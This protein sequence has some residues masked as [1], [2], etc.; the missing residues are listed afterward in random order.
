VRGRLDDDAAALLA[1]DVQNDFCPGGALA[2]PD[3]DA[4]VPVINRLAGRFAHIVLTQ[5]WHPPD[6]HSFASQHG[7]RRPFET[8]QL[9]YGPQTLWPDHCVAGTCGA[10]FHGG[11]DVSRAELVLRK[12]FRR[13]IDSYSAFFENDRRTATGLA[14][15]LRERGLRRLHIAGLATDYCVAWSALDAAALGFEA[16]VVIEDACRAIDLDGSLARAW[17][18]MRAAGVA[19]ARAADLL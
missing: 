14:G 10:E 16:V 15:Y 12:G 8:V 5:D 7:G 17:G 2:V 11:L 4:V 18:E 13:G 1:V 9:G 6:H 19:L 3:G